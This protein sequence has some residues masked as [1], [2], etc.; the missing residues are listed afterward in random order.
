MRTNKELLELVDYL[1]NVV[2]LHQV[3]LTTSKAYS[4]LR[5]SA[6]L[7]YELNKIS[8]DLAHQCDK[9]INIIVGFLENL[10]HGD[11]T[12]TL[13]GMYIDIT[14]QIDIH[15][16]EDLIEVYDLPLVTYSDCDKKLIYILW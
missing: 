11:T 13:K 9:E 7:S 10:C 6:N 15:T 3:F 2:N 12:V 5:T 8:L 1:E 16:L 14:F 4:K